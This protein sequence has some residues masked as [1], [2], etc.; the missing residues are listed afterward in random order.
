[1]CI[2]VKKVADGRFA[3]LSFWLGMK[4][5]KLGYSRLM[6]DEQEPVP[7]DKDWLL[8]LLQQ[9]RQRKKGSIEDADVEV[10][11]DNNGYSVFLKFRES[12]QTEEEANELK[13]KIED[14]LKK[15]K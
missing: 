15:D 7:Y 6:A 5:E 10:K 1:M 4:V 11:K 13:K 3:R 14:E 12:L 9:A 8:N 2:A